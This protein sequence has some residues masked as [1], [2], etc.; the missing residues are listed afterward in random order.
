MAVTLFTDIVG[1][2]DLKSRI[3]EP[4]YRPLLE[5]HNRIFETLIQHI[6]DAE[7]VKHTG[8][9]YMALFN[10]VSSAAEF[11]IDFQSAMHREDWQRLVP[12]AS[13]SGPL[14]SR[15]G[16]HLG[17]IEKIFQGGHD[18]YSGL[19][20]DLANRVMS[21]AMPSQILMTRHVFDSARQLVRP[22]DSTIEWRAHGRYRIRGADEPMELFEVGESGIAPLR[23]P[24]S[25]DKVKR[26]VSEEEEPLLG[27]RPSIGKPIPNHIGWELVRKLGEGGFGEVWLARHRRPPQE[28]VFKF[29]FDAGRLKSL[30]R[31]M[32]L[33][34]H[35]RDELGERPDIARL[36]EVNL[37]SSPF[38]LESA[39]T[40]GG[41][42]TDW[43]TRKGGI[44]KVELATR[45]DLLTQVA[46]AVHAAHSV[47]VIHKDL[48][49]SNILIDEPPH[50]PI[51]AVLADFGISIL[52]DP[53]QWDALKTSATS[54]FPVTS[55]TTATSGPVSLMYAPPELQSGRP[56]TKQGDVYALGVILFQ[57][58]VGDLARPFASGW[59]YDVKDELLREDIAACVDGNVSRRLASAE[60]LQQRLLTLDDRRKQ[61]AD[62]KARLEQER[63]AAAEAERK[64]VR[65][66]TEAKLRQ[67][68]G[69]H[70]RVL[71]TIRLRRR[72]MQVRLRLRRSAASLPWKFAASCLAWTLAASVWALALITSGKWYVRNVL[73]LN[74]LPEV[75]WYY[76]PSSVTHDVAVF[77]YGPLGVSPSKLSALA[78]HPPQNWSELKT[79]WSAKGELLRFHRDMDDRIGS[80]KSRLKDDAVRFENRGWT[81]EA[82]ELGSLAI[83]AGPIS[84][85]QIGRM[86]DAEAHAQSIEKSRGVLD[87][88]VDRYKEPYLNAYVD[89]VLIDRAAKSASLADF[90]SNAADAK[91]DTELG[92]LMAYAD[93]HWPVNGHG[94]DVDQTRLDRDEGT[95]RSLADYLN[96]PSFADGYRDLSADEI[97][98]IL[99][100]SRIQKERQDYQVHV[101]QYKNAGARIPETV[102]ALDERIGGLQQQADDIKRRRKWLRKDQGEIQALASQ[103]DAQVAEIAAAIG[104]IPTPPAPTPLPPPV[105]VAPQRIIPAAPKI[106]AA[107]API[108][109]SAEIV[110]ALAKAYH[111]TN[112]VV[113]ER[114]SAVALAGRF[115]GYSDGALRAKNT[116]N[117]LMRVDKQLAPLDLP[118][119]AAGG[120]GAL[121]KS[122]ED[123]YRDRQTQ[124]ENLMKTQ[125][126]G[127]LSSAA[128]DAI[129]QLCLNLT[130]YSMD[131]ARLLNLR[132]IVD[133]FLDPPSNRAELQHI[134]SLLAEAR[135]LK[136]SLGVDP[137]LQD[138]GLIEQRRRRLGVFVTMGR[139]ADDFAL[140]DEWNKSLGL[141]DRLENV[142][143]D[144][145]T[146]F[147]VLLYHGMLQQAC[148]VARTDAVMALLLKQHPELHPNAKAGG[149]QGPMT[150]VNAP[151]TDEVAYAW[152]GHTLTFV[153]L[154][155]NPPAYVCT[156]DVS[157]RLVGDVI[158]ATGGERAW[159]NDQGIPQPPDWT[160]LKGPQGWQWNAGHLQPAKT[161][162]H[163]PNRPV[164]L[165][166]GDESGLYPHNAAPVA[167]DKDDFP[168]QHVTAAAATRIAEALGC[169]LP[170]AD[171]W[172][173]A[174]RK[175][176]GPNA[177]LQPADW[178]LR[179]QSYA[180]ERNWVDFLRNPAN[181]T[182]YQQACNPDW[183]S[184]EEGKSGVAKAPGAGPQ[185]LWFLPV[186][187]D[188][189]PSHLFVNLIGNV[190]Q[191]V[192][193]GD[194]YS[195]RGLSSLSDP[196]PQPDFGPP[197]GV[198]VRPNRPYTDVGFRLAFPAP[199]GAAT[200]EEFA[201]L[202]SKALESRPNDF[203]LAP[204]PTAAAKPAN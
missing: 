28:H 181:N 117:W 197:G 140:A 154:P 84:A 167:P 166:N 108:D 76:H 199:A 188:P 62:E 99:S 77:V 178:H 22:D 74:T 42:L 95:P 26:I 17:E 79:L 98:R 156:Q 67:A 13:L 109:H 49:P 162:L 203:Y 94:A 87:Q 158:D 182:D 152:H 3:K 101:Q 52:E 139:S 83:A 183:G 21:A 146:K 68:M 88:L 151:R 138:A 20:V 85:Y 61:R 143:A 204:P 133:G 118:R 55:G 43:A 179:G 36:H 153:N 89:Y 100:P 56:Y 93:E 161:W 65:A 190:W 90:D 177:V 113:S 123:N 103:L 78:D 6:P 70:D 170:T 11:A 185:A 80:M 201:Q 200:G 92:S 186:D 187:K 144:Q 180:D 2:I 9:G 91:S 198:T 33:F 8:D 176:L 50:G 12:R 132:T 192:K 134:Q 38:F 175:E 157:V 54:M 105:V 111:P 34:K 39:F 163:G 125:W 129:D 32:A 135:K 122:L 127:D 14:Q 119:N 164:E 106:I 45:L 23:P 1:S 189:Q 75:Q 35:L 60:L 149:R 114:W 27:W 72:L 174:C 160:E 29:C 193:E 4:F 137:L 47:G 31:E 10:T 5:R 130:T 66:E 19:A 202:L 46:G 191:F 141:A 97:D 53:A 184:L 51:R 112:T 128:T 69:G 168:M 171:E 81:A 63:E 107:P 104:Q 148:D 82:G 115:K 196:S 136:D 58:V 30:R 116:A 172:E 64:R 165:I 7:L 131:A 48:K 44:C 86:A 102:A 16:V 57:L 121:R 25:G 24:P 195:V 124:V 41:S 150:Q 15:V 126:K 142:A 96:W 169:R 71:R 37:K 145:R 120:A 173:A 155:T 73:W 110:S 18:D 59:D 40:P 194:S 159:N 147:N